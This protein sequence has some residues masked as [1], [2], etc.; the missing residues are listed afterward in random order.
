MDAAHTANGRC[1]QERTESLTAIFLDREVLAGSVERVTF[2]NPENGF[3]VL[4]TK[5]RGRR[6]LITV[7]GHAAVISVGE[8]ITASGEWVND[9][10]HGQQFRAN[11][12]R[13]SAPTSIEGACQLV[14]QRTNCARGR[15]SAQLGCNT[16]SLTPH[17]HGFASERPVV[18]GGDEMTTGVECTDHVR[19][20][21]TPNDL[22]GSWGVR[23]NM[24]MK[25]P[26][27]H[28][29]IYLP[30][31]QQERLLRALSPILLAQQIC[32]LQ[33]LYRHMRVP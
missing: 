29:R 6:E 30:H 16:S 28:Q 15:P 9:R 4:R 8:W 21:G 13:T 10:T 3:C 26:L 5:A 20:A 17:G 32:E 24:A 12:I 11:F 19:L 33:Y 31:L 25:R 22:V 14:R 27:S 7:V 1:S 23:P 18:G 2:H